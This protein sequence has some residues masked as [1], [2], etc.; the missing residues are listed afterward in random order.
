MH[1]QCTEYTFIL[2]WSVYINPYEY[3][4]IIKNLQTKQQQKQTQTKRK[5]RKQKKLIDSE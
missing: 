4:N 3:Y 2:V 5:I 1:I